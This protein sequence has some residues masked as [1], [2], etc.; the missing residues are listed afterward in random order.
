MKNA[1]SN[2]FETKTHC[3]AVLRENN[4]NLKDQ[5]SSWLLEMRDESYSVAPKIK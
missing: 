5:R 3:M 2:E 1:L 4:D